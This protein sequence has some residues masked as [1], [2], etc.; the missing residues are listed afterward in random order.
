MRDELSDDLIQ[1]L[2]SNDESF[3]ANEF[4]SN[5]ASQVSLDELRDILLSYADKMRKEVS[6]WWENMY[7]VIEMVVSI[8]DIVIIIFSEY[9]KSWIH[10]FIDISSFILLIV[11]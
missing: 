11:D 7:I 2:L 10:L 3:N 8:Q 9:D 4:I 6:S 1:S 5:A